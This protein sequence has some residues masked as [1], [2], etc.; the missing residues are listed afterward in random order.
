MAKRKPTAVSIEFNEKAMPGITGIVVCVVNRKG[1]VG[2]SFIASNLVMALAAQGPVAIL[3]LDLTNRDSSEFALRSGVHQ[4]PL[5]RSRQLEDGTW[6]ADREEVF[7]KVMDYK[8][9]GVNVVID[10][11]PGIGGA[12]DMACLLA[13]MLILPSRPGF[14]D[15]GGLK[16]IFELVEKVRNAHNPTLPVFTICN[17]YRNTK[18]ASALVEWLEE[19]KTATFLGRVWERTDYS[20]AIAQGKA[21]WDY[22]PGTAAA[23]EMKAICDYLLGQMAQLEEVSNG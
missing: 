9:R 20:E 3:D 5:D 17:F 11:P 10:A 15:I 16:R 14:N 21:V 19:I 22:A 12:T 6:M 4:I 7:E 8:D 1:G 13:S 23:V 2:K 18:E